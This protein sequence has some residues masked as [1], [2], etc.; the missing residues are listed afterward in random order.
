MTALTT[1]QSAAHKAWA[2]RRARAATQATI[3]D[4][5]AK[6]RRQTFQRLRGHS[7]GGPGLFLDHMPLPNVKHS[8]AS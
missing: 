6:D 8:T 7:R 5:L 4:D 3:L 2:T 1:M